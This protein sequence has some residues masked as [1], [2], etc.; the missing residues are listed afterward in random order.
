MKKLELN[1]MEDLEGGMSSG[2]SGD[3]GLSAVVGG[4][5]AGPWGYVIGGAWAYY[6]SPK[7]N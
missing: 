3:V 2:C 6:I 5:I 1:Q 4:M 7:C